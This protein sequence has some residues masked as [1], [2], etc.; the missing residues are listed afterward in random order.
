MADSSE[1]SLGDDYVFYRDREDWKDV[2]PV[3]QND[4]PN[5]IVQIAYSDRCMLN[6]SM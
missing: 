1:E 3:P 2:D 6:K 5:P 4:G